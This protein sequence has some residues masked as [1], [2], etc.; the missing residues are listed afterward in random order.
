MLKNTKKNTLY[1]YKILV[2][3]WRIK[4]LF[5]DK[6]YQRVFNDDDFEERIN[7]EISGKLVSTNSKKCKENMTSLITIEPNELWYEKNRINENLSH[8][9]AI[10]LERENEYYLE[11]TLL[12]WVS[13]PPNSY[14]NI[15]HYLSCCNTCEFSFVATDL[16]YRRG[17]IISLS[18]SKKGN[19]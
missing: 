15:R 3:E 7:L 2:D 13:I 12:F 10:I 19:I 11:D 9:G 8:I 16:Y 17:E 4:L 5:N 18:F 14:E 1:I 6:T